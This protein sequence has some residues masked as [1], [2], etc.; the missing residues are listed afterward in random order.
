MKFNWPNAVSGFTHDTY[1]SLLG[2]NPGTIRLSPADVSGGVSTA[3]QVKGTSYLMPPMAQLGGLGMDRPA[4]FVW[5][6]GR[7]GGGT[8]FNHQSL[9]DDRHGLAGQRLSNSWP[10]A[11]QLGKRSPFSSYLCWVRYRHLAHR[12]V[13]LF[14]TDLP[15][16][17]LACARALT[18]CLPLGSDSQI[19]YLLND[20]TDRQRRCNDRRSSSL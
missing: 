3:T 5:R 9:V 15:A 18:K 17:G 2:L 16:Y 7:L 20:Q 10:A 8:E 1:E 13:Y 6:T 4:L 14:K 19:H 11:V 12:V